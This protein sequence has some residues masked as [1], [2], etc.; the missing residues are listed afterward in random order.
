M[1]HTDHQ[2][3]EKQQTADPNDGTRYHLTHDEG[4]GRWMVLS[5]AENARTD[6][7]VR[8][9]GPDANE[10]AARRKVTQLD[11]AGSGMEATAGR[12]L[13]AMSDA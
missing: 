11:R 1:T 12:E 8:F 3:A 9:F 6:M 7:P 10:R 2:V 4:T 13:A 5:S